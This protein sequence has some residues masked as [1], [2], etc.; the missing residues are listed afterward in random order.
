MAATSGSETAAKGRAAFGGV[1]VSFKGVTETA[2]EVF[3]R[4]PIAPTEMAKI[5]WQFVKGRGLVR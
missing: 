4:V 3:G 5:L 1:T 2:E